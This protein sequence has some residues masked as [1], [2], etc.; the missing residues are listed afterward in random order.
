M[1]FGFQFIDH[2]ITARHLLLGYF[3]N[4]LVPLI[5]YL[6]QNNGHR[7]LEGVIISCVVAIFPQFFFVISAILCIAILRWD[8]EANV[9]VGVGFVVFIIGWLKPI[10]PMV[11]VSVLRP[12]LSLLFYLLV[13]KIGLSGI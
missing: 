7:V 5:V 10:A 3:L 1:R 13:S 4:I 9:M 11:K 8:L 12:I 6:P 2:R